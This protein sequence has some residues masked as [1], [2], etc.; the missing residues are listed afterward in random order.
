MSYTV[1]PADL[2]D[3]VDGLEAELDSAIDLMIRVAHGEQTVQ[4]MGEWVS[5]NFPKRRVDL[6][7]DMQV[8]PTDLKKE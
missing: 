2:Q 8:S 1:L 3:T 7:N 5:L 4:A 6:P